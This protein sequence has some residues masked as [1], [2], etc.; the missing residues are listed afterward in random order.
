MS[1]L[2][3]F[4][5]FAGLK[6][7]PPRRPASSLCRADHQTDAV[8]MTM[9][10]AINC[11]QQRRERMMFYKGLL[12]QKTL[13]LCVFLVVVFIV[14]DRRFNASTSALR[15]N[16]KL[17]AASPQESQEEEAPSCS[18]HKATRQKVKA[19]AYVACYPGSGSELTLNLIESLTGI[20]T[21][22]HGG[23]CRDPEKPF[24]YVALKTHYPWHCQN[25]GEWKHGLLSRAIVLIRNPINALPSKANRDFE[26]S[27]AQKPHSSQAP[28]EY[29]ISWR[30]EHFQK[31]LELWEELVHYWYDYYN[32]DN[33][34]F[35]PYEH[36][37]A[38]SSGPLT[39]VELAR[40]LQPE[41]ASSIKRTETDCIWQQVVVGGKSARRSGIHRKKAYR[42]MFTLE[43]YEAIDEVL[44]RLTAKFSKESFGS[45]FPEYARAVA[46]MKSQTILKEIAAKI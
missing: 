41:K 11:L 39:T 31:H 40:F 17:L 16:E 10:R 24:D 37:T 3:F 26:S 15:S 44:S 2:Q 36:I 19:P 9:A 43:Q 30:D 5:L 4:G 28:E 6:N 27:Q 22:H 42:P 1:S 12:K 21:N 46:E 45:I 33:L 18:I 13:W 38:A 8:R 34:L 29:W 25:E 20:I 32:A 35:L 14:T 7:D 23:K